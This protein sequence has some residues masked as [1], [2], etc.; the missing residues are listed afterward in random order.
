M[1]IPKIGQKTIP[2]KDW[3]RFLRV[4]DWFER[5]V[6]HGNSTRAPSYGNALIV[7]T[8]EDGIDARSDTTI[9]SA[10][11]IKCVAVETTTP[12]ER[13]LHETDE[14]LVV[15]NAED[16]D[17]PGEIFIKTTLSPNGT[18]YVDHREW[19][20]RFEC[21]DAMP[22]S[23]SVA[24]GQH[25]TVHPL[26]AAG[27]IDLAAANEF[28]VYDERGEFRAKAYASGADRGSKGV[29]RWSPSAAK[30]IIVT[31]Q[32]HALR[33]SGTASAAVQ[34]DTTQFTLSGTPEIMSPTG[35]IAMVDLTTANLIKNPLKLQVKSGD[36]IQAEWNEDASTPQWELVTPMI[37]DRCT[38][39]LKTAMTATATHTVDNVVEI[40]GQSPVASSSTELTVYNTLGW[41]GDDNGKCRIEYNHRSGHW[42]F[43]Q[44]ECPA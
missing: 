1:S 25:A 22:T 32:P 24:A 19:L 2:L 10:T 20:R 23:G 3:R 9:Y 27:T 42:E 12:G 7:K 8:P 16:Y 17:V 37:W 11:C 30:W 43:Y 39:L 6:E 38:A 44:V 31:L 35:A 40:R 36:T 5:T 18:R 29:A 21:K 4:A 15:Y 26:D 13:T 33:I 41:L 34:F 28:E 14:E